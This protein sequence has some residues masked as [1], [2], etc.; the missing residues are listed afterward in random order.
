MKCRDPKMKK[1]VSLYQFNLLD[2]KEKLTVEA[3]LIECDACFDEVYRLSPAIEMIEKSPEFFLSA[4]EPGHIDM[5]Q[6]ARIRKKLL[7]PLAAMFSTILNKIFEW[8]SNPLAK[9]LVPATVVAAI[10]LML[11]MPH[12]RDYSG[13]AIIDYAS[14]ISLKVRGLVDD[15][16]STQALY[17]QGMKYYQEKNYAEAIVK[18]K[19]YVKR[20]KKDAYGH[21]YLGISLL[22][23]D[24][25][26]DGIRHLKTAAKLCE[27]Q[28]KDIL[29]ERCYWY[30]GNAY[31]KANDV[32][33]ALSRF[34]NVVDIGGEFKE[35]AEKQIMRIQEIRG[36]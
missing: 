7:L 36:E 11:I 14:N 19:A 6:K 23:N 27:K 18:L 12:D 22:L 35:E 1:L 2:E 21:F 4:L 30:L 33:R 8:W 15:L 16:S 31:L 32:D 3:H 20:K 28:R 5:R 13:L 24:A 25:T 34:R 29:L 17:D 26:K 10:I 9:F